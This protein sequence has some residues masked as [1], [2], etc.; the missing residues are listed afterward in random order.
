MEERRSQAHATRLR[1]L[2]PA[3]ALLVLLVAEPASPQSTAEAGV[4]VEGAA[5]LVVLAPAEDAVCRLGRVIEDRVHVLQRPETI[6]IDRVRNVSCLE[7]VVQR[8]GGW[9]H[10]GEHGVPHLV[11]LLVSEI[12]QTF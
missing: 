12:E 5:E 7:A 9:P 3:T 6:E 10:L 4:V 8:N 2:K 1:E 11:R